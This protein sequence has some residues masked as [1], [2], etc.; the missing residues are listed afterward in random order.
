MAIRYDNGRSAQCRA[1]IALRI[2][3]STQ[4]QLFAVWA[5]AAG[6]FVCLEPWRG[7]TDDEGFAGE[8]AGKVCEQ[9]LAPGETEEISYSIE[10]HR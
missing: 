4:N 1:A 5:N 2:L 3:Q 7:R 8:L 9:R 10:F 6:P